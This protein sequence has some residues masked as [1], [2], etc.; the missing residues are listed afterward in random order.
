MV[1]QLLGCGEKLRRADEHIYAVHTEIGKFAKEHE[2]GKHY[3]IG[4]NRDPETGYQHAPTP[5]PG[6]SPHVALGSAHR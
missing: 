2:F 5:C 3:V 1:D 4:L 6:T